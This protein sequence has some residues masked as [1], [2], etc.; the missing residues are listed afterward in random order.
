INMTS[1]NGQSATA[2]KSYLGEVHEFLLQSIYV[3]ISRFQADFL[4][5][6]NQYYAIENNIYAT[7]SR[8]T[9]KSIEDKLS[10][11]IKYL[12]NISNEID[13]SLNSIS[14][15]YWR[16]R[17][18]KSIIEGYLNSEKNS[19]VVFNRSIENYENNQYA[20]ANGEL[21]SLL[22]I[23]KSTVVLYSGTTNSVLSYKSGDLINKTQ[24]LDLYNKV[25]S[26]V[27]YVENNKEEIELAALN[28]EKVFSQM[29][30]DYEEALEARK[31]EGRVKM[32]TGALA[33]AL[34][35]AAIFFTAG[36]ATPIVVTA[37]VTGISSGVYG[38]SN[39]VEGGLDVHYAS[40]GDLNSVAINPIRDKVFMGNRAYDLWVNLNM[41]VAGL[42]IPVSQ[43][44]NGVVGASKSIIAKE[45]VK[46]IGK[47][48]SFA[49][50]VN[51][52][53]SNITNFAVGA[54]EL[55]QTESTLLNLGLNFGIG[56]G[57]Y[58]LRRKFFGEASFAKGM[59]Y[60]DAK[61]YN[62]YWKQVESGNNTGYPGLSDADIKLWKFADNKLNT[63]IALNKVD[64]NE[65]VKL[66]IKALELENS[67][68]VVDKGVSKASPAE[69]AQ[70]WQGSFPY[71]GVDKY[72]NITLKKGKV[73]YVG[74]PYPTGYATT[75][76]ALDRVDGD[77]RKLFEGLQ[78]KPYWEDG[79]DVAEYRGKMMAY[80]IT[81][82]IDVA[83]GI[84]KANPQ[85]GSGGLPQM[86]LP[87]FKE[88]LSSGKIRK[89]E[90]K[91]VELNNYKM[92]L[93]D[94]NKMLDVLEGLK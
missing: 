61:R 37:A 25:Q 11:E 76:S 58:K 80:E 73:I 7:M 69:V 75:K 71:V 82:P 94:Y 24:V 83:F 28:Q 78:V 56:I 54:L 67:L 79:M 77:A 15:I 53:S 63:R 88:L 42:C 43:A 34:G 48:T 36:A 1:F 16:G 2:V 55:N 3:A 18:S 44:V 32:I 41:A 23:L 64:P 72:K 81:E 50:G 85:F 60:D 40:I 21:K 87:D 62:D 39:I 12:N 68:K 22:E 8:E 86:F 59:S 20:V 49:I 4:L 9:I 19:L 13:R 10:N 91:A 33:I 90:L 30:K 52:V 65:V 31:D 6:K 47:E 14:D 45:A 70:S 51:W 17:P 84:T 29:Q 89:V 92:H 5:Y 66:R 57:G 27:E 93:D 46:A 26:S 74:D 38:I 35:G